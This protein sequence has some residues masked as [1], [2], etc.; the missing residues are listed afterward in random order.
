[1]PFL[2]LSEDGNYYF[3]T[4]NHR[5]AFQT[6][7][8]YP[9]GLW[10]LHQLGLHV[11]SGPGDKAKVDI[12]NKVFD[13][14]QERGHLYV[15]GEGR[16]AGEEVDPLEARRENVQLALR[17]KPSGRWE[18][19]VVLPR[20]PDEW[21]EMS[22]SELPAGC[23]FLV[24]G[25]RQTRAEVIWP[26]GGGEL[27]IV[28]P[29]LYDY[30]VSARG[31]WPTLWQMHNWVND[32]RGLNPGV[33]LFAGPDY[34]GLRLRSGQAMY[35]GRD[36]YLVAKE[37]PVLPSFLHPCALGSNNGWQGWKIHI[38]DVLSKNDFKAVAGWCQKVGGTLRELHWRITLLSPPAY[39]YNSEGH[40]LLPLGAQAI[41]EVIEPTN[42]I[43]GAEEIPR[44]AQ[45]VVT[46]SPS[47]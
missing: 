18:L 7:Q 35:P 34:G 45:R 1:M 2:Y 4:R 6:L 47:A 38:P 27:A 11:P 30:T 28:A 5:G 26:Q 41:F 33:T 37:A 14:L 31:G 20:L 21:A 8:I 29:Q 15:K 46:G 36:Y 19:V 42:P 10:Y 23:T 43:H 32:V 40:P 17:E 25:V 44:I 24:Q 13:E 3:K 16:R 12:P 39:G 9:K 22:T